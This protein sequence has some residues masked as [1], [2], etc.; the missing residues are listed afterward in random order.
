MNNKGFLL[1]VSGPSGAGKGTICNEIIKKY[2]EEYALSISAT[3]RSPRGN[4]Q[5]GKEYFFKS[6]EEFEEMIE[7]DML[8][9]YA[10]YVGNYYGTPRKWVED[11]LE[12]GVSVILE[13]DLQGGFQV[14]EKFSEVLTFFVMPPSRD[15][16][17]SRLRGRGTETEEQIQNRIARA[18]EEVE[19]RDK[20]D[21]VITNE[22]VEKSVELLHN[23]VKSEKKKLFEEK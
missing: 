5:N 2:P 7:N 6:R 23:I 14:S 1:I 17:I 3:S 16:L 15:E 20:Y 12:K 22:D 9:E 13:I 10:C 19:F 18:D 4:E 11:Q 21:Y 8:L